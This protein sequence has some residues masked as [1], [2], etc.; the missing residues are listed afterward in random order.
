MADMDEELDSLFDDS[1]LEDGDLNDFLNMVDGDESLENLFADEDD[2]SSFVSADLGADDNLDSFGMMEDWDKAPDNSSDGENQKKSSSGG[3]T[4]EEGSFTDID[5]LLTGIDESAEIPEPVTKVSLWQK[6]KNI[7]K[8]KE[9]TEE[10]RLAIEAEEAEEA[11]YEQRI[12]AEKEEK[13]KVKSEAKAAAKEQSEQKKQQQ[14]E[15]K[16]A[17]AAAKKAEADKK[18]QEKAAKKAEAAGGPIPKS[19]LV[20]VAPL[21]VFIIIGIAMSVVV[22]F[23]SS[24]RFYS[25]NLKDAK[26]LFVH[27]KYSKAYE[28][29]LGL[30]IK[31]KDKEFY[32]Q[33]EIVNLLDD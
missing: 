16:A 21:A 30:D 29:L 27:Q 20:P 26:E 33:V 12:T 25:A 24:T 6:I 14:K 28:N 7:F 1:S 17:K 5:N 19:Q 22:I 15:A 9:L 3:Q 10:Q 32:N 23:G 31:E 8:K 11:E 13:K 2:E 18:K 4:S